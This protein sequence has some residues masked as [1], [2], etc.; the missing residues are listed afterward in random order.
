[1]WRDKPTSCN[2]KQINYSHGY[3]L[4]VPIIASWFLSLLRCCTHLKTMQSIIEWIRFYWLINQWAN[5]ALTSSGVISLILWLISAF[6]LFIFISDIMLVDVTFNQHYTR[7][8]TDCIV[9]LT[10]WFYAQKKWQKKRTM[11]VVFFFFAKKGN[12]LH[13]GFFFLSFFG[14]FSYFFGGQICNCFGI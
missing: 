6:F 1:M 11:W 12:A 5:D 8:S 9:F 3:P 2:H 4:T 13:A 14:I 7:T 10:L